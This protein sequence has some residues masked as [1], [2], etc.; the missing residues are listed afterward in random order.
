M[1]LV[2][3][4]ANTTIAGTTNATTMQITRC[5]AVATSPLCSGTTASMLSVVLGIDSGETDSA[6]AGTAAEIDTDNDNVATGQ[7]LRFDVVA[8]S[9]TAPKGLFV[10]LEFQVP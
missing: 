1:N 10:N 7:I 6:T 8:V 4:A 5:A 2:S 3:V 9:T